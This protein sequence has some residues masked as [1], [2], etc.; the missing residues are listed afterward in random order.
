MSMSV[1]A[2][3][4]PAKA[5]VRAQQ[6]KGHAGPEAEA[7]AQDTQLALLPA[8]C[9]PPLPPG[10]M[11]TLTWCGLTLPQSALSISIL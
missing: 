11:L 7:E 1:H 8:T 2:A 6:R 3:Q 9:R 4:A 10:A 5:Q